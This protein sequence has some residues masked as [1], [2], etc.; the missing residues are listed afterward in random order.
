VRIG[1]PRGL[2]SLPEAH[3]GPAFATMAGLVLYAA[4]DPIDLRRIGTRNIDETG[5][6]GGPVLARLMKAFRRNF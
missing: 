3:S 2:S 1:R 5:G 4:K 6:G